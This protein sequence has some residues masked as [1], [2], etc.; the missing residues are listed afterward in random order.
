[1]STEL[2][3][4]EQ[5]ELREKYIENV[6]VLSKVKDLVLLS[7]DTHVTVK[8]VADYYELPNKSIESLIF[9]HTEELTTDGLKI[10]KGTE[11]KDFKG[12]LLKEGNL[13]N[14]IKF[15]PSLTIIP[16]RAILRI[17]MLL[18]DS[19]VAKKVRNYLLNVEQNTSVE[20]KMHALMQ[21]N[22]NKLSLIEEQNIQII[23]QNT[24]LVSHNMD[25]TE[26]IKSIQSHI[27]EMK[28]NFVFKQYTNPSYKFNELIHRLGYKFNILQESY[29]FTNFYKIL[30][31]WVGQ[32]FPKVP[33]TKQYVL[34]TYGIEL[35]EKLVNGILTGRI[36]KNSKN[37]WVDLNG[38]S[39]NDIEFE[40]V[41][42]EFDHTCAYCGEESELLIPE[43][44][45]PQSSENSVDIIYNIVP[46][47]KKCNLS[48]LNNQMKTWYH[49]QSF[50]SEERLSRIKE[51]WYRYYIEQQT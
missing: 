49:N 39:Q 33:N 3:L 32:T 47:C 37:N 11:L 10:L 19:E 25:L 20:D 30:S 2:Q 31:N 51:H 21:D 29:H 45:I 14:D 22:T 12:L 28:K 36:V 50:Y 24:W 16:R 27:D 8:M 46:S 17:G 1:M 4:I 26:Q 43:H 5:K 6:E 48:K 40:R 41:K 9:D 34:S 42:S 15:A 7:D 38:Y 13:S 35:V 18:R 44:I 23:T